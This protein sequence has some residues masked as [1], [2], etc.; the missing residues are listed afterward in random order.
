MIEQ[1]VEREKTE[2]EKLIQQWLIDFDKVAKQIGAGKFAEVVSENGKILY[3]SVDEYLQY[4][5]N[6]FN[7]SNKGA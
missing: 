6:T 1:K 2:S 7:P 5:L 3:L 4:K